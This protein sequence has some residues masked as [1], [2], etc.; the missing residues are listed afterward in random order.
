VIILLRHGA[1]DAE[2][3][4]LR[5][6]LGELGFESSRLDDARGR[7]LEA[8]G[9]HV[10]ELLALRNHP[11]VVDLLASE[12]TTSDE[13]PLWPHGVLQ[14][15]ILLVL[16][17]VAL[18]IL[19]AVAPAGLADKA[20]LGSIAPE[21][22]S[23]WYLRPLAKFLHT[24][25]PMF[26]GILVLLLW[27]GLVFWPFLDRDHG[28]GPRSRRIALMVRIMGVLLIVAMLTFALLP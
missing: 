2:V 23:E 20:D 16:I 17:I 24:F 1:S 14:I 4:E 3:A 8:H 6:R 13:E 7:A 18:L 28:D 11:A 25:T 19:I 9:H 5:E 22:A 26:G 12:T 15:S 21:G 27:I 10:Q